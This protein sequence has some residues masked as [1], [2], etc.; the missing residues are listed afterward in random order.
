MICVSRRHTAFSVLWVAQGGVVRNPTFTDPD[1]SRS[2]LVPPHQAL[3]QSQS[4]SRWSSETWATPSGMAMQCR[5]HAT[6][7][8]FVAS[9]IE[10]NSPGRIWLFAASS[11]WTWRPP[12][13]TRR[14]RNTA[15]T[16][17]G[18]HM[19][20]RIGEAACWDG[21]QVPLS[22]AHFPEPEEDKKHTRVMVRLTW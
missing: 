15:R 10:L 11:R 21:I 18:A 17:R 6:A 16:A 2:P 1:V 3:Q 4:Q 9:R 19:C 8:F 12:L 22:S 20:M 7:F 13:C 5:G 14:G